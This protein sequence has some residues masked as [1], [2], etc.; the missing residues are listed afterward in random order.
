MQRQQLVALSFMTITERPH[1]RKVTPS[2][3][4]KAPAASG[5]YALSHL[6]DREPIASGARQLW[7]GLIY[8]SL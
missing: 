4:R 1:D 2:E 5:V 3:K 7:Q 6:R 8:K